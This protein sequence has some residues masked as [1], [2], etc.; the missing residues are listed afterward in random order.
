M[1]I[2]EMTDKDCHGVL[3]TVSMGRLGCSLDHQPYVVP[4]YFAY[5]RDYI[6]VFS[7]LGQKI[8]WMRANPKVCIQVEEI[9]TDSEWA[10]VIANGRYQELSEPEFADE[11]VHAREL[12]AKRSEW[13][14]QALAERRTKVQDDQVAPVFFRIHVDSVSGLRASGDN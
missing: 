13:W 3:A 12:L 14:L 5:E 9:A 10:S 1:L 8:D 4:I 2:R 6:Y 7:T 11:N